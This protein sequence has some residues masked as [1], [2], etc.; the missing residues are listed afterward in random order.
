VQTLQVPTALRRGERGA[1]RSLIFF[2]PLP[3]LSSTGGLRR[4]AL[5]AAVCPVSVNLLALSC[6]H[7]VVV[8][9]KYHEGAETFLQKE[10]FSHCTS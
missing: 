1:R 10:L 7:H 4:A 5:L 9:A 8:M 3:S 6:W 2:L